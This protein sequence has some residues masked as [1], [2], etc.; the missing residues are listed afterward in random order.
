MVSDERRSM[1]TS[2][3]VGLPRSPACPF[4][5]APD[6]T[7]ISPTCRNYV[8]LQPT[9]PKT[10]TITSP[11]MRN[12]ERMNLQGIV[13]ALIVLLDSASQTFPRPCG[14]CRGEVCGP[15][16]LLR[17]RIVYHSHPHRE[18]PCR[19]DTGRFESSPLLGNDVPSLRARPARMRSVSS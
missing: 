6:L 17:A 1:L 7:L 3:E 16:D 14:V 9:K 15:R 2:V 13:A 12:P 11:R 8:G 10:L 4:S 5:Q 18:L 19:R